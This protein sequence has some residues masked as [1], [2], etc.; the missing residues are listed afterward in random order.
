MSVVPTDTAPGTAEPPAASAPFDERVLAAGTT[1]RFVL[2]LALLAAAGSS[3][4]PRTVWHLLASS[5]KADMAAAC[6]LAA[7]IDP[8]VSMNTSFVQSRHQL[9][10]LAECTARFAQDFTGV[11]LGVGTVALAAAF[12]V[13]WL[14]PVW[15]TRR[16]KVVPLD[17][18]DVHGGLRPLLNELVTVTGLDRTPS[19]VVDPASRTTGAIAFG[20]PRRPVIR[21]DGGLVVTADTERARFRAVVL[22][23]LAHLHNKDIGI[24]YATVALWRVFLVLVLLP[25]VAVGM[26][27]L[28]FRGTADVR[29]MFAPFNT[30]AQV[31]GGLLVLAVYLSRLEI[32]R[33]REIYA[34]L[35]AARWGASA[36]PWEGGAARQRSEGGWRELFVRFAGLWHTHP[37]QA[38]RRASL[39]DPKVLFALK[40]LPLLLAGLA[41]DILVWHLGA[42]PYELLWLK[43]VLVAGLVVGIGGVA[44][45]R[46]VL[47]ALLAGRPVPSGWSVGLWLGLGVVVGELTGPRAAMNQWLPAHPEALLILVAALVLVM[48]WTAQNAEWWLRAWRGR[49][50]GPVMLA[51]LTVPVLAYASVLYWWWF[52][53]EVLTDG[54]PFTTAGV[55]A[56]YNLPGLPPPPSD[57]GLLWHVVAVVGLLPGTLSRAGTLW[58]AQVLLWALPLLALVVASR[59][60]VRLGG[61]L[62]VERPRWLART[63]P[64]AG[65]MASAPAPYGPGRLLAAGLAGGVVCSAGLAVALA[66]LR[67]ADL[68][69]VGTTGPLRLAHIM[70]PVLVIC[71]AMALTAA[72]VAA[73]TDSGWLTAGLGAAGITALLG[74]GATYAIMRADASAGPDTVSWSLSQDVQLPYA[75][76]LG[77]LVA[78]LAAFVGRGTGLLWR[79]LITGRRAG[80]RSAARLAPV[81][82]RPLRPVWRRAVRVA[83]IG[84]VVAGVGAT[85]L[86]V[87]VSESHGRSSRPAALMLDQSTPAPSAAVSRLQHQAWAAAGGLER[88]Q[89]LRAAER[90]YS[91]AFTAGGKSTTDAEFLQVMDRM[92]STCGEMDRA[93]RRANTYFSVPSAAGQR[94]WARVLTRHRAM[95]GTCRALATRPSTTTAKAAGTARRNAIDSVDAMLY[96]LA[97]KGAI[98]PKS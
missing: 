16:T 86:S 66:R 73:L 96:W 31:L 71:A 72:V 49:S 89:A 83:A 87:D 88:I 85:A 40:A 80:P 97:E 36:E 24:T 21:L 45:W 76:A 50:L 17:V 15:R 55:L 19:F 13:Y 3:M 70:G 79:W 63:L 32:V 91:A 30:H 44:L 9:A 39:T 42:L 11:A 57:I 2:L 12:A 29:G 93:T 10:A 33:H 5:E 18:I 47:Y 59:S 35:M 74:V 75:V 64:G 26:D 77:T 14:L 27:I 22:H 98:R 61:G 53:G 52:L 54:W 95:V 82:E 65:A 58:W 90:T 23:E 8:S 84:A 67:T 92:K 62:G 25:W 94:M 7:G 46:A 51:G 20:R 43:A 34:D 1:L 4:I 6:S 28:F 38:L 56:S 78:G 81:G 68:G 37:S 48:T 69:A 60:G 41:A